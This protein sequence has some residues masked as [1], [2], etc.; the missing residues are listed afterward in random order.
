MYQEL[1]TDALHHAERIYGEQPAVV[2]GDE[3]I[4][5]ERFADNCR[6]MAATLADRGIEPGDRVAALLLNR[7]EYLELYFAVSGMGA[8]LVP[9]NLRH[10]P[11]ELDYILEDSGSS[12]LLTESAT[13][14]L[15]Q[16]LGSSVPATVDV[17]QADLYAQDPI[18]LGESAGENEV[19]ALFYTGGTTGKAK[20]V[21]LSHRNLVSNAHHTMLVTGYKAGDVYLH[22]APMFHLADGAS[23]FALTWAG[24]THT[25]LQMFDPGAVLESIERDRVTALLGIPAMLGALLNHPEVSSRDTSSLRLLLHGAAPISEDLFAR[26][27]ETFPDCSF[28]HVYGMTEAAPILTALPEE[29]KLL[30]DPLQRSAGRAVPGVYIDVRRPDG[31]SCETEEVGEIVA[32]GP[33]IMLGYWNQPEATSEVLRHGVYWTGDLGYLDEEQYLFVV[34]RAKDMIITGG[35]NVYSVE[36]ENALASHP[37][38]LEAAVFG[39][40]DERWG[41]RVH[42][43]VA[44]RLD[45]N[46]TEGE[47]VEHC[48]EYIGGYKVP[49]G[50]DFHEELPKSGAGKI[51][52]RQLRE[53]HPADSER[54]VH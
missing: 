48:R 45:Q 50:I 30:G 14:P 29:E 11:A 3:V 36:V 15:A 27:L 42:A 12:V 20:G 33:N 46:A 17:D 16:A 22:A 47:L 2:D 18:P 43:A 31:T 51:L 32:A 4:T 7:R 19:A 26:A 28:A 5:Y 40:P 49:K 13:A 6:R 1:V 10:A 21:M 23:T 52:K 24:G 41:E 34:D 39:V 54:R 44:L 53:A 8:I 35:E 38:V 37:A 9:L 25:F